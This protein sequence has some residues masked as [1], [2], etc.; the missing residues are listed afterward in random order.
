M[1]P[2]S[3]REQEQDADQNRATK[4]QPRRGG[5]GPKQSENQRMVMEVALGPSVT[6]VLNVR[7]QHTPL[8]DGDRHTSM[9]PT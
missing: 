9:W 5:R 2:R 3:E 7:D 4:E 6:A 8:T 1:S